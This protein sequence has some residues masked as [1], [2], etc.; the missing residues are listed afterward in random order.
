LAD[1][2]KARSDIKSQPDLHK[3]AAAAPALEDDFG[4]KL[5]ARKGRVPPDIDLEF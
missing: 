5:M 3:Q 4:P 1:T 2:T